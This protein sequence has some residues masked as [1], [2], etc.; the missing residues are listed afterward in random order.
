M[1]NTVVFHEDGSGHSPDHAA[2][3]ANLV[4][5]NLAAASPEH[6]HPLAIFAKTPTQLLVGGVRGYTHWQWLVISHLWIDERSRGQGLGRSLMQQIERAARDRNCRQAHCDTFS[7]QAL[8]FYEKLGYR[9]FGQLSE[10]P[11]GQSRYFL[12]KDL[13]A[14]PQDGAD[15]LGS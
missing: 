3:I 10:Y 15:P 6:Y 7:F 11:P 1:L 2:L 14:P 13:S 4:A 5:F 12:T 9:R 8:G